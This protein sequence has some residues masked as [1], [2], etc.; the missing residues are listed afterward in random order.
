VPN[1]ID[2]DRIEAG[3]L[4]KAPPELREIPADRIRIAWCG[5]LSQVKSPLRA[6]G[7]LRSLHDRGLTAAHLIVI[8]DG[9]LLDEMV[10]KAAD[11]N[12]TKAITFV[13]HQPNP[14]AFMAS[15]QLG[16]ITSDIEGFPNVILEMLGAGVNAIVTTNCAGGL[17]EIPGVYVAPERSV[18][19]LTDTLL[20]VDRGRRDPRISKF[21]DERSPSAFLQA[22][23]D[24]GHDS[25]P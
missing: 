23:M 14:V 25:K 8:G 19:A 21:L 1:P 4:T 24:V 5:R 16:L 3:V 10:T 12:L 13:G 18:A 20:K 22:T 6:I 9:P 11:E 17:Q 15:A 2:G 7:V